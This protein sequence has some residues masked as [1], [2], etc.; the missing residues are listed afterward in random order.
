MS[1]YVERL[2]IESDNIKSSLE[3]ESDLFLDL[4]TLESRI[5]F[6]CNV[7]FISALE[8]SVLEY[9]MLGYTISTASK[10]LRLSRRTTSMIFKNVCTRIAF[11]LGDHFT[12]DGYLDYMKDKYALTYEDISKAKR[13]MLGRYRHNFTRSN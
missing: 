6:L 5:N 4:I 7:G 1:W 2:I 9:M 8:M 11:H 12:D 3:L 13:Y 10:E